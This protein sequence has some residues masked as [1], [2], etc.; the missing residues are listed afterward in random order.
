MKNTKS[1]LGRSIGLVLLTC[2]SFTLLIPSATA[3]ELL[4]RAIYTEE[5]VGDLDKAIQV[6]EKVVAE[7]KD[8][9]N[10]AAQAQFRI[11]A[12]YAKQG[13]TE[14]A[15]AAFQA[16][17]DNYPQATDLVA[18]AIERLPKEPELLP[19]P[20][21]DGDELHLEMKL[22]TGLSVGYQIYRIGKFEKEGRALWECSAWQIVTLN[23]QAGKSRV[24][25][26]QETF[27]PIKSQW[28]HSLLG[29]AEATYDKNKVVIKLA[30]K[31]EPTTL[32]LDS[33]TYDN[34]QG[35]ELFRRLPMK[36]GYKTKVNIIP[37]LTATQ[38]PLGL[39]V[40]KIETIEVPAGEFECFRLDL[41][42][43]QTFWISNDDNR[44]LVKFE[45]GGVAANLTKVRPY[46]V[47]QSSPLKHERF[48]ATLPPDWF[49]FTPS[50]SK[51][52]DKSKTILIDPAASVQAR[53]E[54]NS[55]ESI[56]KVHESP[57]AWLD[58][59]I[60]KYQ[61]RTKDFSLSDAGIETIT[62]GDR[63]AVIAT[64]EFHE[65][66]KVMEGQHICVFGD[67]SAVNLQFGTSKGDFKQWQPAIKEI[68][69]SLKVE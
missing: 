65:G 20:W 41:D 13:K 24:L 67:S 37:I 66:D 63:E 9:L 25:V 23:N 15:N 19:V 21:G 35:A 60:E 64:F 10:A 4:E 8:S 18:K 49:A 31:D 47:N 48:S 3:S 40:S 28:K 17:I 14:Q 36:V 59:T 29:E 43:G 45:A 55:L 5:T 33:T 39:E 44:Y 12:C 2:L 58:S 16:V 6:Y 53:I 51:K 27:A 46:Q 11:G 69:A 26:D 62:L 57:R 22:P 52:K 61:N 56:K 1:T 54:A 38:V 32:K 68:L 34:E 30:N 7:G 50:G 42:I